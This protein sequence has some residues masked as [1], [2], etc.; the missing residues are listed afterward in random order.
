M[1]PGVTLA[2]G[3][4]YRYRY[5][6]PH[7]IY[8]A[9]LAATLAGSLRRGVSAHT[10]ASRT[11]E[12]AV[13]RV[14][15]GVGAFFPESQ[16]TPS[17]DSDR[18]L[19]P[20]P[21]ARGFSF[22]WSRGSAKREPRE[23]S[24]PFLSAWGTYGDGLP[25]SSRQRWKHFV[26]LLLL[27][28]LMFILAGAFLPLVLIRPQKFCFFFTIGSVLSMASFA[29]LRGPL[30]Q[31]KHMFSLQRCVPK[32]TRQCARSASVTRTPCR[33]PAAAPTSWDGFRPRRSTTPLCWRARR[34]RRSAA[35]L[36]RRRALP[37]AAPATALWQ[38]LWFCMC[39]LITGA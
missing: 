29:V 36:A 18:L 7:F 27:S 1:Q 15:P 24:T 5:H 37:A 25:F 35:K 12:A 38:E 19:P 17:K 20:S 13:T 22:D 26:A 21:L 14:W 9:P 2:L 11:G 34:L 32:P 16:P 31:L 39:V 8:D 28:A 6:P 4:Q 3:A 10:M 33:R 30:E 23:P